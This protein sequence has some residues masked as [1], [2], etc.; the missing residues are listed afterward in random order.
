MLLTS[1]QKR[2]KEQRAEIPLIPLAKSG[3]ELRLPI[4]PFCPHIPRGS[5]IQATCLL[6]KACF[7]ILG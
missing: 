1:L 4:R 3:P 7:G 5:V 6:G 2:K